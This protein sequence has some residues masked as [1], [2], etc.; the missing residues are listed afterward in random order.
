MIRLI[1]LLNSIYLLAQA[2]WFYMCKCNTKLG[3]GVSLQPVM[4][5]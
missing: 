3:N 1:D 5:I 4:D 2:V